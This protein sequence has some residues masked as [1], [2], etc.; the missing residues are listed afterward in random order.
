MA[1][2]WGGAEAIP[3]IMRGIH[4]WELALCRSDS[5]RIQTWQSLIPT[6]PRASRST[7]ANP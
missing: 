7:A 5:E 2:A 4:Y 3:R 1:V 6:K